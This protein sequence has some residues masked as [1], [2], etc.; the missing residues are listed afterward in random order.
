MGGRGVMTMKIYLA[1]VWTITAAT[2]LL[3]V[4]FSY[5]SSTKANRNI[6]L[7]IALP[8]NALTD[9]AVTDIVNR[10]RKT[11]ALTALAL[12]LL[13]VPY[14]SFAS[15]VSLSLIHLLVWCVACF[16]LY[17]KMFNKYYDELAALKAKKEWWVGKRDTVSIDTQVSRLKDTFPLPAKWFALPLFISMI[18]LLSL[19]TSGNSETLLWV[20]SVTGIASIIIVFL[21]SRIFAKDKTVT[22]SEDSEINL[23]LNRV[24]QREWSKNFFAIA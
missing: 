2:M 16:Y 5:Q 22:Y 20:F 4:H 17:Q 14:Y 10:Y 12:L 18:P 23:A 9:S 11:N 1:I 7:G 19:L 21:I 8:K 15:F 3:A 6:L 13:F 24:Y